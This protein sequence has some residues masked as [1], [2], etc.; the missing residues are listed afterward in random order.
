MVKYLESQGEFKEQKTDTGYE[1]SY[2]KNLRNSWYHEVTLF[3]D[4]NSRI[5]FAAWK[6]IQCY[7]TIFSGISALVRCF[8]GKEFI[9]HNSTL[10]IYAREFLISKK[11]KKFFLPPINFHLNQQ[12]KFNQE[13]YEKI[14]SWG[15]RVRAS[16]T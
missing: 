4:S 2:F 13:N 3:N 12:G 15:I 7:Y 8:R 10:N 1:S 6:I 9:G 14:I 16:F 5:K 11:R